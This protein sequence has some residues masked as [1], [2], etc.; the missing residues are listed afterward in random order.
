[1]P[2]QRPV[3]EASKFASGDAFR[4]ALMLLVALVK[5]LKP[6]CVIRKSVHVSIVLVLFRSTQ[7][8]NTGKR[9]TFRNSFLSNY[10]KPTFSNKKLF[11]LRRSIQ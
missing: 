10:V 4:E 8:I 11:V 9:K 7:D 1:M 3:V 5:E 2:A 6:R